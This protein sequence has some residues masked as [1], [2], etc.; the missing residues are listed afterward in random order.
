MKRHALELG[1]ADAADEADSL[2]GQGA[3][4]DANGLTVQRIDSFELTFDLMS[5]VIARLRRYA[6]LR[7]FGYE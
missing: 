6:R 4:V 7:I 2:C 3:L 5:R 1:R